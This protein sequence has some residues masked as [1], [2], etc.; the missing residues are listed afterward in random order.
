MLP[1]EFI[2]ILL[3][4]ILVSVISKPPIIFPSSPSLKRVLLISFESLPIIPNFPPLLPM[5]IIVLL[6]PEPV[7]IP[8]C[9]LL[10]SSFIPPLE[11]T[12]SSWP[13]V[14]CQPAI[15]PPVKSTLDPTIFPLSFNINASFDDLICWLVIK[16]PPTLPADAVISR[17][18][19]LENLKMI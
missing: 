7:L 1:A 5:F 13:V 6:T 11:S 19:L 18:L 2:I 9:L 8:I 3:P 16:N 10:E 12:F 14:I 17:C 15:F 4:R